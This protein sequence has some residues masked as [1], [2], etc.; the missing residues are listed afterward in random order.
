[1]RPAKSID[2]SRAVTLVTA[3]GLALQVASG[4][5]LVAADAMPAVVTPVF[6]FRFALGRVNAAA[7]R[8]GIRG[9]LGFRARLGLGRC[10]W[11]VVS[12]CSLPDGSLLSKALPSSQDRHRSKAQVRFA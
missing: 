8:W 11:Q 4:V 7:F 2:V 5:V 12:A 9:H 3:F 1:L 10:R 6:R